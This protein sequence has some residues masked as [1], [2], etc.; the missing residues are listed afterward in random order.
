MTSPRRA[1]HDGTATSRRRS[2][3]APLTLAAAAVACSALCGSVGCQVDA[4]ESAEEQAFTEVW[5][6]EPVREG[7]LRVVSF[8]IRNFP[9]MPVDPEAEPRQEPVSYQ[10]ETD[11]EAL[12]AVLGKLD[13]DVMGVQEII[14]T[15]LLS[16]VIGRLNAETGRAYEAVFAV[17]ENDN[18]QH[19]GIIVDTNK[20]RIAWVEE[21]AEI[22]LSGR[23]R[24]GLSARIESLTEGGVDFGMMVLHLASGSSVSRA[25][26][27]AQQAAVAAEIIARQVVE[28]GDADYLVVGDLNT[29]RTHEEFPGIDAAFATGTGLERQ[30]NPSGCTSYWIKKSTNPLLRPS[31]LDH[32]YLASFDE[33]DVEVPVL[34]GAHCAER[35]CEQYESTDLQSGSTFYNVSDHCPVYF[36]IGDVDLD[37]SSVR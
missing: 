5:Q 33:L 23:L 37:D 16:E 7:N 20:A 30:D 9:F 32:V 31:W 14:D 19:V 22:D 15:A 4:T 12:L 35:R 34:A 3:R 25:E 18:P 29:A 21:H 8:N 10:L 26:L 11:Q 17:N 24:P 2:W 1:S 6:P 36:E 28:S 13:F 27:R